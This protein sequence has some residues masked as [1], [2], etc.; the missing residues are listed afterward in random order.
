MP[1]PKMKKWLVKWT[2]V[3]YEEYEAETSEQAL[4]AAEN[5]DPPTC[6][7]LEHEDIEV[8]QELEDVQDDDV[9]PVNN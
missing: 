7:N 9:N 5:D 3:A 4:A 6:V 1:N 8:V 2:Y